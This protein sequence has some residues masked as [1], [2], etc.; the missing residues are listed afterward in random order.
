MMSLLP[1]LP[2]LLPLAGAPAHGAEPAPVGATERPVT[3]PADSAALAGATALSQ[4]FAEVAAAVTPAAVYIEARKGPDVAAGL[5]ELIAEYRLPVPGG[6]AAD[7]TTSGSGVI[8][9]PDGLVLTNHHV[10]SGAQDPVVTL[11]DR[12]SYPATVVG[13][14]AR[15][16]VALLR[17]EGEGPFPWAALGDSDQV[18]VGT[19]V[20][21]VGHPFDFPFTV[22]TGIISARG[23]RNLFRN[24]IQ[25]YLQTDAAVNPGSSGGPL[26]DLHG[27]VIGINTAIYTPPGGGQQHA[28]ISFAI[29]AN[30]AA[31]IKDELLATGR[32]ARASLGLSTRDRPASRGVPRPGAEITRVTPSGP[33][34]AAGLRRGDVVV[35]VDEEP[36]TGA[37]DLRGLVQARGVRN[38]LRVG[39]EREG[40]LMSAVVRTGDERDLAQPDLAVPPEA[41]EWA[42]LTLGPAT[43]EA[44]ATFGVQPPSQRAPGVLVLSVEP[45]A[46]GAV[47]GVLP[48][49][50]LLALGDQPLTRPEDAATLAADRR[51]VTL[52]L[53][54]DGGEAWAAVGGLR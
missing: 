2:W 47:A 36:I 33:A 8:I 12:R 49:D 48:G 6:R 4:A 9:S 22:T 1:L 53:W 28:G 15:T 14:D 42:G 51:S 21:A 23:R 30:M 20:L 35:S 50:L 38:E 34:E 26:F 11:H 41:R 16:D 13:S 40:Q 37:D 7:Q 46:P 54:R 39:W 24:E 43:P 31:R 25:D 5:Q 19:W 44:L 27:R 29:P 10:V 32:V 3:L 17:I 45:G 52:R 18:A